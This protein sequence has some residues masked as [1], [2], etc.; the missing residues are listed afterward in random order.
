MRY[1]DQICHK[2]R[3]PV[4]RSFLRFSSLICLA[5][6]RVCGAFRLVNALPVVYE[7][8]LCRGGHFI[9]FNDN[10]WRIKRQSKSHTATFTPNRVILVWGVWL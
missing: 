8:V 2:I 5:L 10:G 3:P 4:P 1:N 9:T 7:Q 6:W